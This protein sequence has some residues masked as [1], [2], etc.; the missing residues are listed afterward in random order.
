MLRL[1]HD[2]CLSQLGA[3]LGGF[4]GFTAPTACFDAAVGSCALLPLRITTRFEH[5]AVNLEGHLGQIIPF[6]DGTVV[7]R[8][9]R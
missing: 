9:G 4:N 5:L 7:N 1:L 6:L 8:Q 2:L 3:S